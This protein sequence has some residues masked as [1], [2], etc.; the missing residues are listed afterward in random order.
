VV[1]CV[2]NNNDSIKAIMLPLPSKYSQVELCT[3]DILLNNLKL[4]LFACYRP[5]SGNSDPDVLQY[6]KDLCARIDSL[7]PA[8]CQVLICGDL[9]LP[10][11]HRT[12]DN[13]VYVPIRCVVVYFS[14]CYTTMV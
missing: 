9:N 11:I 3:L 13:S 2:I 12:T 1:R 8:H 4:R 7:F 14:P 5:P 10:N 6:I